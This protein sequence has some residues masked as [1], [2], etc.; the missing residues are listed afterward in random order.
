[1]ATDDIVD[2]DIHQKLLKPSMANFQTSFYRKRSCISKYLQSFHCQ[3]EFSKLAGL[4][5]FE[6]GGLVI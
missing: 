5:A 6:F 1:M 4:Q 2:V 3:L